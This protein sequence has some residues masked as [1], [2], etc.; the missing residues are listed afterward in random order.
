MKKIILAIILSLGASFVSAGSSFSDNPPRRGGGFR[1]A[2]DPVSGDIGNPGEIPPPI[3]NPGDP[4]IPI[5]SHLP[6]NF[7]VFE[8]EIWMHYG[9]VEIFLDRALPVSSVTF[10]NLSNGRVRTVILDG[11]TTD[12]LLI[13]SPVS[14]NGWWDVCIRVGDTEYHTQVYIDC[15]QDM[16]IS[17]MD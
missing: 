6:V 13:P 17:T 5:L 11:Q 3:Y 16:H 8:G 7:G 12:H 1:G 2:G 9:T 10:K 15:F 14:T 4:I